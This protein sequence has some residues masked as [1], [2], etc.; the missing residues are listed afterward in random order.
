MFHFSL[1]KK[2]ENFKFDRLSL[3]IR[4]CYMKHYIYCISQNFSLFKSLGK[5][6]PVCFAARKNCMLLA[7]GFL[8]PKSH[9]YYSEVGFL[10]CTGFNRPDIVLLFNTC[11]T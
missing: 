5:E 8:T 1:T 7:N 9:P 2:I 4:L 11:D 3:V 10:L 6:K